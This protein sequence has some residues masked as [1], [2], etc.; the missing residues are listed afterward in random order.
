M[1]KKL[2]IMRFIMEIFPSFSLEIGFASLFSLFLMTYTLRKSLQTTSASACRAQVEPAALF[3]V[4]SL[5][6]IEYYIQFLEK[7]WDKKS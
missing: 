7:G 6:F 3:L 1:L 2:D 4:Y 5:I